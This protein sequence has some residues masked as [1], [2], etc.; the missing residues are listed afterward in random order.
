MKTI[1]ED[2]DA[3]W[4]E[5]ANGCWIW[6]RA[7]AGYPHKYGVFYLNGVRTKAH[8]YAYERV[9]GPIPAGLAICHTCDMPECVNPAHLFAGTQQ[10]NM[11]DARA[12]GRQTAN[13]F[14]RSVKGAPFISQEVLNSV[15]VDLANGMRSCDAARKYNLSDQHVYRIKHRLIWKHL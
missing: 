15:R 12:K 5:N 3:C 13:G 14:A 9:Y 1:A 2:F 6:Q 10:D 7:L 8:R 4:K 11:R